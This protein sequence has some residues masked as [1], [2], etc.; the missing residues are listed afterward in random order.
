[1]PVRI[2][3]AV[4]RKA[5]NVQNLDRLKNTIS[6]AKCTSRLTF[7][8]TALCCNILKNVEENARQSLF[9]RR[10]WLDVDVVDVVNTVVVVVVVVVCIGLLWR[11]FSLQDMAPL[12]FVFFSNHNGKEEIECERASASVGFCES[13]SMRGRVKVC[14]C[15]C[16]KIEWGRKVESK[17]RW[18]LFNSVHSEWKK[19]FVCHLNQTWLKVD[20]FKFYLKNSIFNKESSPPSGNDGSRWKTCLYCLQIGKRNSCTSHKYIRL[21]EK[22]PNYCDIN[23]R[24]E[25][26]GP[27]QNY[28]CY[29]P[30]RSL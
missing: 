27:Y 6:L 2:P 20:L 13:G 23:R 4:R 19:F 14:V 21:V 9:L 22:V 26:L 8:S 18:L 25:G 3:L 10:L 28:T 30:T 11:H 24:T 12:I 29:C 5:Q 1:M 16:V 15:V 17:V 7:A